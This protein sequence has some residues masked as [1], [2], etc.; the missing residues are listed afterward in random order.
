MLKAVEGYNRDLCVSTLFFFTFTF[1]AS[2]LFA[3]VR[4]AICPVKISVQQFPYM[5][6]PW[7][8]AG[9]L[10]L[11]HPHAALAHWVTYLNDLLCTKVSPFAAR[12]NHQNKFSV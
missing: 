3:N 6:V 10:D 12:V 11:V 2:V 8:S 1:S 7:R 4:K 5:H 9:S